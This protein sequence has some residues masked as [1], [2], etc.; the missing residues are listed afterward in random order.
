MPKDKGKTVNFKQKRQTGSF[1]VAARRFKLLYVG[2]A[3]LTAK[4]FFEKKY[5]N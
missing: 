2:S 5:S 3:D 4:V 1:P